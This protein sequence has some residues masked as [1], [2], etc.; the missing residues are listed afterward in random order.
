M[1]KPEELHQYM[2]NQL[3]DEQRA[4]KEIIGLMPVIVKGIM[5]AVQSAK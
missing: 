5:I 4:N 1:I 2:L 3:T